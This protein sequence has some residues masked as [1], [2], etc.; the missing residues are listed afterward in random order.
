[1]IDVGDA[2]FDFE[3]CC[4]K[5]HAL[6]STMVR[7]L[8]LESGGQRGGKDVLIPRAD[9]EGSP[10]RLHHDHAHVCKDFRPGTQ[11]RVAVETPESGLDANLPRSRRR[12]PYPGGRVRKLFDRFIVDLVR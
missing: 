7:L 10:E 8:D 6:V 9:G 2:K 4:R 1:M 5:S 12:D 3:H 11:Q